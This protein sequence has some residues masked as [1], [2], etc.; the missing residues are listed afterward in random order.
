MGALSGP[1]IGPSWVWPLG[2]ITQAMTSTDD[3]E[4][5]R[6]LR[7]LKTTHAGKGFMHEA[8]RVDDPTRY[9]RDW[10][11]WANTFFGELI[12]QLAQTRPHLLTA[13]S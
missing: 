2:I 6:C 3:A 1:H 8:F 5:L 11:A 9:T 4:I 12:L 13:V 10:F 7:T